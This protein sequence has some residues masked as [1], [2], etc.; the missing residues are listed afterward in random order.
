MV[1]ERRCP[2][3]FS[4]RGLTLSRT[5]TRLDSGTMVPARPRTLMASMACG[6]LR[7]LSSVCTMTSYCS[8]PFL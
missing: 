3:W 7:A 4:S 2:K 8:A 1:T 5:V 6:V